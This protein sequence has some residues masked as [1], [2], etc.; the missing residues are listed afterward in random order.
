MQRLHIN[1]M[2]WPWF[3][4][5]FVPLAILLVIVQPAPRSTV[6]P[7]QGI[8]LVVVGAPDDP[9]HAL[10]QEIAASEGATQ[11]AQVTDALNL[12]PQAIIWVTSPDRLLYR[13]ML[14]TAN[15]LLAAG[16]YPPM[17]IITASTLD[18]ARALWQRSD[19]VHV[20]PTFAVSTRFPTASIFDAHILA[21]GQDAPASQPLTVQTLQQTLSRAG[22][23]TYFGHGGG[24]TWSIN[25]VTY[26]KAGD[27]PTLPATVISTGSC[28]TFRPFGDESLLLSFADKGVA[29][30]SG[31]TFS[32]GAGILGVFG[33]PPLQNTWP[34]FP[35]GMVS[36]V[37][38]EGAL[39]VFAAA[40]WYFTL[41]DPRIAFNAAPPYT[42][43]SETRGDTQWTQVYAGAPAG[44]IPVRIA[45]GAD[46]PFVQVQGSGDIVDGERGYNKRLQTANL[47]GDKYLLYNHA[48]GDFTV[49]LRRSIPLSWRILN[50]LRNAF[51]EGYINSKIND[52]GS[53]ILV[54]ALVV[55]PLLLW[56]RLRK[57]GFVQAALLAIVPAL[58]ITL[59]R[60]GYGWL[61]A[62]E[63]VISDKQM[64]FEPIWYVSGFLLSWAGAVLLLMP[65][66]RRARLLGV[67]L[68]VMMP[69]FPGAFWAGM[70]GLLNLL[71]MLSKGTGGSI[72][73]LGNALF[74]LAAAAA[75]LPVFV[76]LIA[77]AGWLRERR[78]GA[79]DVR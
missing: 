59:W 47:N 36:R 10:A 70:F 30:Y 2:R 7:S 49:T 40:P 18:G 29:S 11:V 35:I 25:D 34:G 72:Y 74:E 27:V 44:V 48:G 20:S 61:R 21:V 53:Y 62:G 51:D 46:W 76:A 45:D 31:F 19:N 71:A 55:C 75:E 28:E 13:V 77:L 12:S 67:L 17:G 43:S 58:L 32:P 1:I 54:F 16:N 39:Q 4:V 79:T 26:F 66:N 23:V 60:A 14:R 64:Y 15:E 9:Y 41:G 8:D 52:I 22:Y 78:S 57:P 56:R 69:L 37:Q 68:G 5:L 6:Y 65:G 3:C 63:T 73:H 42:L 38:V 33:P 24:R 50:P